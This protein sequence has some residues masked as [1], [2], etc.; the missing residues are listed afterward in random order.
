MGR[1]DFMVMTSTSSLITGMAHLR[2]KMD[3]YSALVPP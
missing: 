3:A 2:C 1:S